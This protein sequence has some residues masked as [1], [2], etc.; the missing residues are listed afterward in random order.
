MFTNF[1]K[2]AR[3][4]PIRA[5]FPGVPS[6]TPGVTHSGLGTP[7]SSQ[8]R[9]YGSGEL[10]RMPLT[11]NQKGRKID[12][13]P[14]TSM[15]GNNGVQGNN[16]QPTGDVQETIHQ[17]GG[18]GQESKDA[19]NGKIWWLISLLIG[20]CAFAGLNDIKSADILE[21]IELIQTPVDRS[22]NP[23]ERKVRTDQ[24][25]NI[26]RIITS[27]A[28]KDSLIT[29]LGKPSS[30]LPLDSGHNRHIN[31]NPNNPLQFMLALS[32]LYHQNH[33]SYILSTVVLPEEPT[34]RNEHLCKAYRRL[35]MHLVYK[36]VVVLA[37]APSSGG[38]AYS[39]IPG[40]LLVDNNE[41]N[42]GADLSFPAWNNAHAAIHAAQFASQLVAGL[43][44]HG[45]TER[46]TAADVKAFLRLFR[47]WTYA[48]E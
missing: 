32:K 15:E 19:P 22:F 40:L 17:R 44:G 3:H 39:R 2:L 46:L 30:Y 42:Y 12:F 27:R 28:D 31:V 48:R 47:S 5:K 4:S 38:G 9:L 20:L 25:K 16:N 45:I 14:E 33:S 1:S 24:V 10:G 36:G 21:L 8:A 43:A 23:Y 35:V 11:P 6:A 29:V 18:Q 13:T 34:S 37:P 26:S 41:H 7:G